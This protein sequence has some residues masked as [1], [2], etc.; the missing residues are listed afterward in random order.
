MDALKAFGPIL[1]PWITVCGLIYAVF[2]RHDSYASLER[3]HQMAMWLH[4]PH[5]KNWGRKS[6]ISYI[7]FFDMLFNVKNCFF[8]RF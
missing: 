6:L 5:S 7:R 4:T 1:V 8:S 2:S 3:K